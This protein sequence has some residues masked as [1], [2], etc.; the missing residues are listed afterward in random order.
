MASARR[1]NR[2]QELQASLAKEGRRIEIFPADAS[3]A[4]EMI[5]LA[6]QM[7]AQIGQSDILVDA[8]GTNT[9]DRS[10]GTC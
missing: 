6:E 7:R 1:K 3:K 9:P 2:L 10:L 4:E 8:A 5:Q